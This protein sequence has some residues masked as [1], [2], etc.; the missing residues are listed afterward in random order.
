MPTWRRLGLSLVLAVA[1]SGLGGCKREGALGPEA[2]GPAVPAGAGAAE[3]PFAGVKIYHAPYSNAD[4]ARR[5]LEN[6]G[7][8]DAPA[9]AK[10]ADQPQARWFGSWSP[11]IKT[12]V[13]N[14]VNAADRDG[15]LALMVAYNV[16]NRDC[17]QYSKGGAGDPEAYKKWVRDYAEG[18]GDRRAV[19]VLEPDAIPQLKQCL[20][21]PDQARRL[22]L[23]RDAVSVLGAKPKVAV[24]IDAGN[25]RWVPAPEMAERLKQ[26][27]ISGARGFSLNVSNY[28]A[29]A[30]LLAYGKQVIAALGAPTHF[31][32]DSSRNGNGPTEDAAWCNPKGRAL[33]R[34][35]TTETGEPVLD[36]Y[37][38]VKNPGESDGECEGGP[39]AGQWFEE[40]ALE[41]AKNAHW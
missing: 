37:V 26:A 28:L 18:I 32:I 25:S 7:S 30:E 40:R 22:D 27:G 34:P 17:G 41:M 9:V 5:R 14:F 20:S 29:D 3:N 16:P 31:I 10:I 13:T 6:G 1:S 21:E 2:P 11:D 15:Q 36:A 12:V 8:P 35:P 33:G 38:W 19:V 24:Y 39:A 23:I 4:Q